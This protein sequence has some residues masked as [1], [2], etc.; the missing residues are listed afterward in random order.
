MKKLIY[1]IS[2]VWCASLVAIWS[3]DPKT[4]SLLSMSVA[5]VSFT[6]TSLFLA[7]NS[8]KVLLI[9]KGKTE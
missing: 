1:I 6:S 8:R 7:T 4:S 3:V 9:L 2:T 5:F